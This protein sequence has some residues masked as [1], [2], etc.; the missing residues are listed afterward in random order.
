MKA[1]YYF[2]TSGVFFALFLGLTYA[3]MK[4]QYVAGCSAVYTDIYQG[5]GME[6][7]DE[8]A[9]KAQCEE[10]WSNR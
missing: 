1:R 8:K 7:I 6:K 3:L 5:L 10:K 9:L 2:T 4:T